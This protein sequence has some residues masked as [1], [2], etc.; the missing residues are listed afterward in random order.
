MR[1]RGPQ[2]ERTEGEEDMRWGGQKVDMNWRAYT[3]ERTRNEE[4]RR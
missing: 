1:W 3:V 4:D 2:V